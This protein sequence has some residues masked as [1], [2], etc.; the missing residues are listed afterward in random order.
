M[1]V[2]TYNEALTQVCDWFD[3]VI[4]PRTIAR[5]NTNVIYLIFKAFAKAWE[6]INNTCVALSNKFDPENCTDSDL[7]SVAFLVG[8]ERLGGSS[9]GLLVTATNGSY[10]EAVLPEGTYTYTL[11][12][13]TTFS[14]TLKETSVPGGSFTQITFLSAEKG[15][16]PVTAQQSIQVTA[17]SSSGETVEIPSAF[18]FSNSDNSSLLGY[19]DESNADFRKRVTTDVERQDIISE[20]RDEIKSLPFVFD[21]DIKFND[22]PLDISYD[23]YTIPPFYML[24][25]VSGELKNEIAEVVASKGIYP[26]VKTDDASFVTYKNSVFADGEYTVWITQYKKTDFSVTV[27]VDIDENYIS[28]GQAEDRIQAGLFSAVNVNRHVDVITENDIF[29]DVESLNITGIKVLGVNIYS[30]EGESNLNYISFQKTRI[31]NLTSVG[32]SFVTLGT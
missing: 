31:P 29:E 24:L 21:C 3:S 1:Q 4:S 8:T 10:K 13:N 20:I 30:A 23:G 25:M 9:S 27:T 15:S 22:S 7:E 18:S 6:V 28:Q 26:T 2:I 32:V 16:F 19:P 5:T 11:D 14:A 17:V 12:E